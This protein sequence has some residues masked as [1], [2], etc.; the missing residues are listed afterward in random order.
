MAAMSSSSADTDPNWYLDSGAPD[1]ITEEL[2]KL[3]LHERYNGNNHIRAAN[4]AGMNIS[5]IGKYVILC[6]SRPLH[7]NNVLHVPWARG[8]HM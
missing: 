6:S 2:E 5:Q 7:L 4:G 8:D 1:H 3:T